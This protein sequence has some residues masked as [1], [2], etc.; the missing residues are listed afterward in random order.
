VADHLGAAYA[1]VEGV[2]GVTMNPGFDVGM[3]KNEVF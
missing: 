1:I 2:V 3:V